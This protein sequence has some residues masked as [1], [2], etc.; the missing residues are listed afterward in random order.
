MIWRGGGWYI[1]ESALGP[2]SLAVLGPFSDAS[3]VAPTTPPPALITAALFPNYYL[4]RRDVE[5]QYTQSSEGM[6]QRTHRRG[7]ALR[8]WCLGGGRGLREEGEKWVRSSKLP[9]KHE[10]PSK[11]DSATA[12]H[13][14]GCFKESEGE[15]PLIAYLGRGQL[16]R[17]AS[18][19][20]FELAAKSPIG[21]GVGVVEPIIERDEISSTLGES[22][23]SV[24]AEGPTTLTLA[25]GPGSVSGSMIVGSAESTES[26]DKSTIH[27]IFSPFDAR[28]DRPGARSLLGLDGRPLDDQGH[29]QCGTSVVATS[30]SHGDGSKTPSNVGL[31]PSKSKSKVNTPPNSDRLR[32]V[33]QFSDESIMA[34]GGTVL[35]TRT[36]HSGMDIPAVLSNVG[37]RKG[38]SQIA[39]SALATHGESIKGSLDMVEDKAELPEEEEQGE[40]K[41]EKVKEEEE[42]EKEEMVEGS[43]CTWHAHQQHLVEVTTC[44]DALSDI[45][46][47]LGET[48]LLKKTSYLGLNDGFDSNGNVIIGGK[49]KKV[50]RRHTA[51]VLMPS[52]SDDDEEQGCQDLTMF[53]DEVESCT[54]NKCSPGN[55]NCSSSYTVK[56]IS[57]DANIP[58]RRSVQRRLSEVYQGHHVQ[59]HKLRRQMGDTQEPPGDLLSLM[60][61]R[62]FS[63]RGVMAR[64][65][66]EGMVSALFDTKSSFQTPPEQQES[67]SSRIGPNGLPRIRTRIPSNSAFASSE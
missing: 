41:E 25:S 2:A 22:R 35:D 27:P 33:C 28:N 44:S 63:Q 49:E 7:A 12:E 5:R 46:T 26:E 62:V 16:Q 56:S 53:G 13:G 24:K 50:V 30:L 21:A 57:S 58:R 37:E 6:G 23:P 54:S 43:S 59:L 42:E 29:D 52:S 1:P 11:A 9:I 38:T 14:A 51:I 32:V 20:L 40:V 67:Q 48:H 31:G 8:F 18:G 4:I 45:S 17:G 55:S 36:E 3:L 10:S 47:G 61:R 65:D 39:D 66:S 15:D 64:V 19:T 60:A 34:T